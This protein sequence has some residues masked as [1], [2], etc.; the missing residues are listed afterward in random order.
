[1]KGYYNSTIFKLLKYFVFVQMFYVRNRGI[2]C[3]LCIEL[4]GYREVDQQQSTKA[5]QL[6]LLAILVHK[7]PQ[8]IILHL[9]TNSMPHTGPGPT[10]YDKTTY[11]K[12]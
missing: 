2:K 10:R 4:I 12:Y 8:I 11:N 6:I 1:M 9:Y 3:F 5:T 7:R